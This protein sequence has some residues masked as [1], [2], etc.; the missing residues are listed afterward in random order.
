MIRDKKEVKE[1]N[2]KD[3][4]KAIKPSEK[5]ISQYCQNQLVY[6]YFTYVIW[7]LYRENAIWSN[8]TLEKLYNQALENL[9][10]DMPKYKDLKFNKI[11]KIL[12]EQYSI[13]IK[14]KSPIKIEEI[15]I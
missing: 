12:E 1:Y 9:L 14:N 13:R 3:F 7:T 5:K 2:S 15:K 11:E 8:Y 10:N 4:F 6:D